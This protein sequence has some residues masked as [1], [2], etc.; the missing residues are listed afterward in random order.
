MLD[1]VRLSLTWM[2]VLPL[3]RTGIPGAGAAGRAMTALP[4]VGFV[5]GLLATAAA[6]GLQSLGAGALLS[7]AA[8]VAV[9]VALTRG[10]HVDALA[11]TAD[12]LGSYAGPERARE[13]MRSGSVGPMGTATLVLVLLA[14]V[15]ALGA[16]VEAGAWLAPVAALVLSRCLPV[17]QLRRGVPAASETGFGALV[18]GSQSRTAVAV[19]GVI[20][21]AAGAALAGS[22][23][24]ADRWWAPAAGA[25]AGLA[26]YAA[27]AGFAGHAVRRFDGVNGDVLGATIEAGT[28]TALVVAVLLL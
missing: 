23:W 24:G 22:G 3:G 14:E 21:V 6:H 26:A 16:L 8:G 10:M 27:A 18:A 12:A 4:V 19:I 1:A 9:V 25:T 28:A 17:S 5:C 2:T 20:S 7:G 15:A 13:I 11:D